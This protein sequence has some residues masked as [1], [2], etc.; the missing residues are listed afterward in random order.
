[1]REQ[2][3][4]PPTCSRATAESSSAAASMARAVRASPYP[5][6]AWTRASVSLSARRRATSC[7]ARNT[8][9]FTAMRVEAK[10]SALPCL[11]CCATRT[12]LRLRTPRAFFWT[13]NAARI[14]TLPDRSTPRPLSVLFLAPPPPPRAAFFGPHPLAPCA[15]RPPG[16]VHVVLVPVLARTWSAPS[17]PP[18]AS[19]ARGGARWP[20]PPRRP[21]RASSS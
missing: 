3:L 12:S 9:H 11:L 17:P 20:P 19:P 6:S 5:S 8:R 7:L 16:Y 15:S 10:C 21:A 2:P 4:R 1:M 13:V 14:S 18:P